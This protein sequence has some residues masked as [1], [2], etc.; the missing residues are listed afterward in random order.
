LLEKVPGWKE[1]MNRSF[2]LII[3]AIV[4]LIIFSP[5]SRAADVQIPFLPGEKLTLHVRWA[6]IPAGE[7]QLEIL[8]FEVVNGVKSYRSRVNPNEMSS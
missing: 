4:I 6:F 3:T 1:K 5:V 8:P 2:P 7:V